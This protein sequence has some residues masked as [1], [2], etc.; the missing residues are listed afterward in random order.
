MRSTGAV[1]AVVLLAG[2]AWI[3]LVLRPSG[4][5]RVEVY[6]IF[7]GLAVFLLGAQQLVFSRIGSLRSLGW[8]VAASAITAVAVTAAGVAAA[9]TAMALS[10]DNARIVSLALIGGGAMG[11]LIAVQI[12]H[13]LTKDLG[14]VADTARR[15][16][17]GDLSARTGVQRSDEVGVVAAAL[18]D[19]L[20]RLEREAAAVAAADSARR[21]LFAAIGHDLRT[22]LTSIRVAVEALQ[23]GVATDPDRYL[24]SM[25]NDIEVLV[26]LVDD[27]FLL[28]RLEAGDAP[29][30]AAPVDV[31]DLLATE[32]AAMS[33]I[34]ESAQATISVN[35]A[36]GIWVD[37]DEAALGRVIR[38]LLD[39]AVRHSPE[40]G[41]VRLTAR[42]ESEFVTISV[43]DEG[44]GFPPEI[45][46]EAFDQFIR[47][48]RA[49]SRQAGGGAGLGL[50][51]A[52]GV[53]AAHGGTIGLGSG[54][55]GEVSFR[56]PL[57]SVP[58][59]DRAPITIDAQPR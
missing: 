1:I 59:T 12:A 49:R 42:R 48:D 46:D 53:V 33:V 51:I 31:G 27:L 55:G 17:Q 54:P 56:L 23:D 2:V 6:A 10:S 28:T 39:N 32:S 7:G 45:R 37:A 20:Q 43:S 9:T 5:S 18:D 26:R 30:E 41:T 4:A 34:A 16:G 13:S 40:G 47:G 35:A 11:L 36:P 3:E 38:N 14:L 19:T 58:T 21:H 8:V 52:R 57:G 44:P 22:P 29:F 50:S 25:V 24:D 15:L